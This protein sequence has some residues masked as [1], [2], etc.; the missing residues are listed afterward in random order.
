MGHGLALF[1]DD[2]MSTSKSALSFAFTHSIDRPL[3]STAI[4]GR[5]ISAEHTEVPN[6]SLIGGRYF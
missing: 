4:V 2:Q 1:E 5:N 6:K 3:I